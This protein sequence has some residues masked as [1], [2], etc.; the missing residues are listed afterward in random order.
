MVTKNNINMVYMVLIVFL[1]TIQYG[2]Y[3]FVG[4]YMTTAT[5]TRRVHRWMHRLH[6]PPLT[7]LKGKT[8]VE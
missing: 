3:V 2:S 4:V 1:V 8:H 7:G 5:N 6:S